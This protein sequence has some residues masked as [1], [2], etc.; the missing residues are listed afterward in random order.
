MAPVDPTTT[1]RLKVSYTGPFGRHTM[2]F[3]DQL[4]GGSIANLEGDVLDFITQANDLMFNGVSF[5]QAEY[6][7]PGSNI[8]SPSGSWPG[9]VVSSFNTVTTGFAPSAFVQF[10][11]RSIDTGVR[12]KLYLFEV[13]VAPNAKMRILP[14]A[15]AVVDNAIGEL[16]SADNSISAIDGTLVNWKTYVNVGQND[17]LTHKARN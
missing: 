11:G 8:F 15:N 7:L 12:V 10:G 9:Y 13:A 1:Y 14:G 4:V 17:H 3:H 16:N 2:L 5:D 6:A